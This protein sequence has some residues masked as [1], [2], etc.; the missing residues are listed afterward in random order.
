MACAPWRLELRRRGRKPILKGR[1]QLAKG[2]IF[3]TPGVYPLREIMESGRRA[4]Y[5]LSQHAPFH[6]SLHCTFWI[7]GFRKFWRPQPLRL[8]PCPKLIVARLP[9]QRTG[10][11]GRASPDPCFKFRFDDDRL[12]TVAPT[13]RFESKLNCLL[14]FFSGHG[15]ARSMKVE[16]DQRALVTPDERSQKLGCLS[17]ASGVPVRVPPDFKADAVDLDA[18]WTRQL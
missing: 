14:C 17:P 16:Y 18:V 1:P 6:R 10:D 12:G 4:P 7:G 9:T 2:G 3:A 13:V 8:K 5:A 11:M 15:A